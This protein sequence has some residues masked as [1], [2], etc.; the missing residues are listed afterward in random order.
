MTPAQ[1]RKPIVLSDL[2]K[3]RL[4][5]HAP[6]FGLELQ[7][8]GPEQYVLSRREDDTVK[9]VELSP[10]DAHLRLLSE[11]CE[12]TLPWIYYHPGMSCSASFLQHSDQKIR[13]IGELYARSLVAVQAKTAPSTDR[14]AEPRKAPR[15]IRFPA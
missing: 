1:K 9:E 8:R 4:E 6:L 10:R 12:R 13:R 14:S 7:R 2:E 5:R 15:V 3:G 11:L